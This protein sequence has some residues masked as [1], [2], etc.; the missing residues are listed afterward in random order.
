MVYILA[1]FVTKEPFLSSQGDDNTHIAFSGEIPL[2]PKTIKVPGFKAAGLQVKVGLIRSLRLLRI[3]HSVARTA[4][5][6]L[7]RRWRPQK[8]IFAPVRE[9]I[10]VKMVT[11]PWTPN[12]TGIGAERAAALHWDSPPT[13]PT[14]PSETAK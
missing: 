2:D 11:D 3:D 7:S 14:P 8:N 10:P 5:C 9:V 12:G 1:N 6:S 13:P 4:Y